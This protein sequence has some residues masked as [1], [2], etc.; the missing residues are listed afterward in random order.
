MQNPKEL[1]LK[2]DCCQDIVFSLATD[3]SQK[4]Q[5]FA[6]R[7]SVASRENSGEKGNDV[8]RIH[9]VSYYVWPTFQREDVAEQPQD[10]LT[11]RMSLRRKQWVLE[12][13]N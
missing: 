6:N 5:T 12:H 11:K 1:V 4:I 9:Q 10:S 3:E 8:E 7:S 2:D 13:P